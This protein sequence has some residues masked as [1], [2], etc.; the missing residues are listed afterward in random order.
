MANPG[1]PVHVIMRYHVQKTQKALRTVPLGARECRA[2]RPERAGEPAS[3]RGCS[4][5]S[6]FET[7]GAC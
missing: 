6:E 4:G 1:T 3:T 2:D 7:G 5:L